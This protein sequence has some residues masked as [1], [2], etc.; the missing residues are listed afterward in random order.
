MSRLYPITEIG[1]FRALAS[2]V[3]GEIVDMV[4]LLGP[5]TIAEIA[6]ALGRPA[7]SLY[8]HLRRLLRV[9]LLVQRGTRNVDGHESA[10]YDVPGRPMPLRYGHSQRE[11]ILALVRSVAGM[12][13]LAE[14]DFRLAF[15]RGLVRSAGRKRN[16]VHSRALGWYTDAEIREM[17]AEIQNV[18]GKFRGSACNRSE[19]ERLYALT[20]ILVP[21]EERGSR[22]D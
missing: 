18:I 15:D 6:S 17:Q 2:P 20:A 19:G 10:V 3:R 12:L 9:G 21:L 16:V 5:A 22:R 1:Q 8:Y 7:D 13:R 11:H 14:R 4:D